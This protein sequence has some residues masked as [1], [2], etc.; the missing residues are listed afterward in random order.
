LK[1]SQADPSY[2]ASVQFRREVYGSG[3]YGTEIDGTEESLKRIT[4][5][6]C[7][8][9]H[10]EHFRAG[11]AFFV[12]AGDVQ[13]EELLRRLE[14]RFGEWSGQRPERPPFP[15][16]VVPDGPYVVIVDRPA[17]VQS[18]IRIG[19]RAIA[20]RDPDYIP[21]ITV[22]TLFGGYFN[23]RINHNLRERNGYTYGA[24]SGVEAP[25]M[26]GSFSV[27]VSVRTEVTDAATEEI[28]NELRAITTQPVGDE[29]LEMVK[30]YL[31]GSQALQ[32][33]TPGQVAGFVRNIALY[34]LP[35]DYYQ[36]LPTVVRGLDRD[37]LL[38]VAARH[39]SPDSMVVVVVGDAAV[40]REKLERFGPVKVVDEKGERKM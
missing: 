9:F 22:N 35:A 20:R 34:G 1:Q 37:R 38:A 29:E 3:P 18:A 40:I 6:H 33:E 5:E 30:S 11:G 12:A 25:I 4:R 28:F 36:Q 32:I 21:L 8:A 23:S 16:V 19:R 13:P 7:A 17:S 15:A 27:G 2:L 24:R 31:I 26:P 39:M 10:R 14:E